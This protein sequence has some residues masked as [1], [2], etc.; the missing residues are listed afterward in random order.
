[1]DMNLDMLYYIKNMPKMKRLK[2]VN[3]DVAA[4]TSALSYLF[5]DEGLDGSYCAP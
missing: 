5:K 3:L 1:M 2:D 4:Y